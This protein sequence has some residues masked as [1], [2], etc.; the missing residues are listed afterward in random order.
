MQANTEDRFAQLQSEITT[1]FNFLEAV[2][3]EDLLHPQ[4]TWQQTIL[5]KPIRRTKS[6]CDCLKQYAEQLRKIAS[7]AAIKYVC[8][9]F[10]FQL[11]SQTMDYNQST[12]YLTTVLLLLT[13]GLIFI[14]KY[15]SD[16]LLVIAIAIGSLSLLCCLAAL[17]ITRWKYLRDVYFFDTVVEILEPAKK[18]NHR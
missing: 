10:K 18:D 2:S 9:D 1:V 8:L 6:Q 11:D 12:R 5:L 16:L 7:E 14:I 17:T 15:F 3:Q 13:L 4:Q